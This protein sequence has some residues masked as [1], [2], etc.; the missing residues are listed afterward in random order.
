MIDGL[1]SFL[2]GVGEDIKTFVTEKPLATVGI[3]AA[4]L[5]ATALGVV[6]VK[7]IKKRT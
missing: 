2:T 5:G 6:A 3:G 1:Q 4:V 7:K